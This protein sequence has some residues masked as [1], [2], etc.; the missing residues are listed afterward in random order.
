M[1]AIRIRMDNSNREEVAKQLRLLANGIDSFD[2][3]YNEWVLVNE[4]GKNIGTAVIH[5]N[6]R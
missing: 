2:S 3:N 6:E 4:D 1:I 5:D